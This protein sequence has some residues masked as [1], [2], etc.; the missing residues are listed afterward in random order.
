MG[1][2]AAGGRFPDLMVHKESRKC[3]LRG[4]HSDLVD[5]AAATEHSCPAGHTQEDSL[6]PVAL[7]GGTG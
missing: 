3:P 4:R 1:L 7:V 5:M 6:T 2:M